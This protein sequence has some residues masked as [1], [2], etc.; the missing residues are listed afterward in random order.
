MIAPALS[1]LPRK[2]AMAVMILVAAGAGAAVGTI[3][4]ARGVQPVAVR[5]TSHTPAVPLS[6]LAAGEP[7]RRPGSVLA[8]AAAI[9]GLRP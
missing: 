3:D 5:I 2:R 8:G 1:E 4:R 6:P 7:C 9:P